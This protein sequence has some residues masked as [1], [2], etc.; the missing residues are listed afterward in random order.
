MRGRHW[1]ALV[2]S[3]VAF[4]ACMS[5]NN[6]QDA[7]TPTA[8]GPSDAFL[9]SLLTTFV[10]SVKAKDATPV[11]AFYAENMVSYSPNVE[12]LQG[13]AA[14]TEGNKQWYASIDADSIAAGR[15][16]LLSSGDL[17]VE[18]GWY[19]FKGKLGGQAVEDRGRYINVWQRQADGSWKVVRD[20]TNSSLPVPGTQPPA[21]GDAK[22]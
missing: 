4:V 10:T 22:K 1:V 3:A 18:T 7:Q 20:M 6:A 2:V 16:G 13:K 14:I 12:P 17:A 8:A 9:D 11:L 21:A 15:D 19:Y 5:A